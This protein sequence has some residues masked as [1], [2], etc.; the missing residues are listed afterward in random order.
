MRA[1][2]PNPE[3]SKGLGSGSSEKPWFWLLSFWQ[4]DAECGR[5]FATRTGSRI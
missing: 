1:A 4:I 2:E 3:S 5:D